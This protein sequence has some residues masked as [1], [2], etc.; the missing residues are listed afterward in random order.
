MAEC[1][2]A[3]DGDGTK[4]PLIALI[5]EDSGRIRDG[6]GRATNGKTNNY[7]LSG[8]STKSMSLFRLGLTM[9]DV[10]ILDVTMGGQEG[11]ETLERLREIS[12]VPVIALAGDEDPKVMLDCLSMGADYCLPKDVSPRELLARARALVRRDTR[13][14]ASPEL[15]DCV[16]A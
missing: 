4:L 15:V 6:I 13:D 16:A 7:L 10:V 11:L 9:P 1:T 8:A 5:V 12:T 2:A 14:F 3:K